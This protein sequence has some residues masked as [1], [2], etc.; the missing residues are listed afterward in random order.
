[1]TTIYWIAIAV[2]VGAIC[3][4]QGHHNGFYVGFW[5]GYHRRREEKHR[6]DMR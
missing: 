6:G 2:V 4:A 5:R 1:M 3:Y